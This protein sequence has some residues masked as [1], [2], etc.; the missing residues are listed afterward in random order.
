[1]NTKEKKPAETFKK[2]QA[3]LDILCK[4]LADRLAQSAAPESDAV[5]KLISR[6]YHWLCNFWTPDKESYAGHGEFMV[7][8]DLKAFYDA[9][10]PQLAQFLADGIKIYADKNL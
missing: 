5:Q 7:L 10:H 4:D 8:G 6:H 9:Y 1:M 3:E 2:L